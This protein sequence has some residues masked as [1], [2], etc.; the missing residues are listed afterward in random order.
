MIERIGGVN[1]RIVEVNPLTRTI[2]TEFGETFAT[3]VLLLTPPQRAAALT[4]AA[5]L[6]DPSGWRPVNHMTFESSLRAGI[7]VIYDGGA[8]GLVPKT[9]YAD[10]AEGEAA[11]HSIVALDHGQQQPSPVLQS[12]VHALAAP[13]VGFSMKD[14]FKL[15]D[16]LWSLD[17][18]EAV[19]SPRVAN[20]SVRQQDANAAAAWLDA[21]VNDLWGWPS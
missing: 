1:H 2:T 17:P 16:S 6:R 20:A 12:V 13:N 14:A 7:H 18:S 3:D 5:G 4:A 21:T 9:A 19:V 10:V 8:L 11:A 15:K